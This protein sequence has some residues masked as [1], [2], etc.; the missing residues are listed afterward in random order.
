MSIAYYIIEQPILLLICLLFI[1]LCPL[2]IFFKHSFLVMVDLH[3]GTIPH[4]VTSGSFCT[5]LWALRNIVYRS[6]SSSDLMSCS[7][8]AGII[9]LRTAIALCPI[10][11]ITIQCLN[12]N[13]NTLLSWEPI[14]YMCRLA[15][16]LLSWELT[17]IHINMNL[18]AQSQ[19]SHKIDNMICHRQLEV[20][21]FLDKLP[22]HWS[23]NTLQKPNIWGFRELSSQ[24]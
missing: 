14:N 9:E 8:R 16:G 1:V 22:F 23:K 4:L 7:A 15:E 19:H 5:E 2:N 21:S 24:Q 6:S 13:V 3:S 12:F 20:E 18:L 17:V 11:L 10:V